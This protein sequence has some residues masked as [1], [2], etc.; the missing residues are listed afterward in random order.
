MK[1]TGTSSH[2]KVEIG[3]ITYIIEGERTVNGFLAN[4]DTISYV[5]EPEITE[6]PEN[7]ISNVKKEVL[8]YTSD[9]NFKVEF[10]EKDDGIEKKMR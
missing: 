5:D 4:L 2:I 6:V 3:K 9:K 10:E 7:E 1:I 8:A